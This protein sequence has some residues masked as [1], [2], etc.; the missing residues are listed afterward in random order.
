MIA[1]DATMPRRQPD[2]ARPRVPRGIA[3]DI[4]L[5]SVGI[6]VLSLVLPL[7]LLQVYDRILPNQGVESLAVLGIALALC[8]A[9]DT[10][11]RIGRSA[12]TGW[13]GARFEHDAHTAALER[14]FAARPDG[15]PRE[16]AGAM[17]ERFESIAQLREFYAGQALLLAVDFPFA[18]AFLA[19]MALIAG[20]LAL[21]PVA[22]L[23]AFVVLAVVIGA[24]L[25]AALAERRTVDDRR[26]NFVIEVLGGIH[27]VKGLGMEAQMVRRYERLMEAC[28]VAGYG[29]N[30][31]SALAQGLG[32]HMA[33]VTLVAVAALGSLMVLDGTLTVGGLAACTLLAGRAQQPLL[34][35][36]G[37]WTQFQAIRVARRRL[38]ELLALEPEEP[39]ALPALP[40]VRGRVTLQGVGFAHADGRKV[41][42]G[43]DLDIRPGE[44]VAF[45][46][47]TG[48]GRSTLLGLIHGALAPSAGR[49][50]IDGN[51]LAAFDRRSARAQIAYLPSRGVLFEGTIMDNLTMFRGGAARDEAMAIAGALGLHEA[52]ARFPKGYDTKVGGTAFEALPS[53]LRQRIA[54]A[55]ALVGKPR[56][57]LYDEADGQLDGRGDSLLRSLLESLKGRAT[58]VIVS[59]RPSIAAVADRVYELRDGR[60]APWPAAPAMR[61][62]S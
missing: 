50:L 58:L 49:V 43:V 37:V 24:R 25:R 59:H 17:L 47:D 30:R 44:A 36:M 11:L 26:F 45:A 22:L 23:A 52:V 3:P 8:L 51:D 46:G 62:A 40:P 21:V 61:S 20:Q 56:I 41:L 15:G 5:A 4:I 18:A 34:R 2:P 57:V 29:V 27:T 55:R 9:L 12:L 42:E 10:G 1:A 53:G 32:T 28:G 60:L 54:I 48:A 39:E 35:A 14:V 13:A 31:L 7:A 6:N 38:D 33:Q 19:L 16:G